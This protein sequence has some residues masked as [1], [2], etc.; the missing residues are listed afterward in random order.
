MALR[1]TIYLGLLGREGLREVAELCVQKT[2]HAADLAARIPGYRRA[3][4]GT[5]FREFVLECPVDA[6][7]VIEA[8]RARGVLPG[9]DLGQFRPEWRRCL[10]VAVTEQRSRDEI[11]RWA[12]AL[13]NVAAAT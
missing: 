8:G 6:G 10:L 9:V 13:K 3:H 12:D 4:G 5:F 2:H 1:A 7:A 11:H